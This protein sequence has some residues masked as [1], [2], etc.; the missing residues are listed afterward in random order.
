MF[1]WQ[2]NEWTDRSNFCSLAWVLF[3][4]L[5]VPES[6]PY[7]ILSKRF[8]IFA[9]QAQL[10]FIHLYY[11]SCRVDGCTSQFSVFGS[12]CPGGRTEQEQG[13][14]ALQTAL[15]AASKK[16]PRKPEASIKVYV[17]W[18]CRTE[19]W[20]E[21]ALGKTGLF[22]QMEQFCGSP[23]SDRA[24]MCMYVLLKYPWNPGPVHRKCKQRDCDGLEATLNVL[25][26][27]GWWCQ[28]LLWTSQ[29]IVRCLM[30]EETYW[31][32]TI[33]MKAFTKGFWKA[34]VITGSHS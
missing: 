9:S 17:H 5:L 7:W 31:E 16:T 30:T 27:R 32:A 18:H 29:E 33:Q 8:P 3:A 34:A 6:P 28:S 24:P 15:M 25:L 12:R 10:P 26:K 2:S 23:H 11:F 14:M 1:L 4:C 22:Q 20:V 21:E 19:R 13:W